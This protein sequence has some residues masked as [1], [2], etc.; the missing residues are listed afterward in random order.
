MRIANRAG[1]KKAAVALARNSPSSCIGRPSQRSAV[2]DTVK[3]EPRCGG[4][5]AILDGRL[6]TALASSQVGTEEWRRG[7]TKEWDF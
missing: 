7:R 1:T 3:D 6:R 4:L 5:T 2:L